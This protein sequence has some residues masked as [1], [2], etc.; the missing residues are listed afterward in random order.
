MAFDFL[1]T[2]ESIEQFE[3]FEEFVNIEARTIEKKIDTLVAQKLRY[4]ELLDK[5]K[6]ADQIQ[7]QGYSLAERSDINYIKN[8]RNQELPTRR[9]IDGFSSIAVDD[10]KKFTLEQIKSKRERN[11][12][13]IKK[14]RDLVE[15]TQ[16]EVNFLTTQL[17]KYEDNLNSI[18]ARFDL[19]DYPETQ[20]VAPIDEKDVDPNIPVTP[21]DSGREVVNGTT[22]Y[23]VLSVKANN[24]TITFDTA[25]PSVQPNQQITLINGQNNGVKTV[26][27]V[28]NERTIQVFEDL[29]DESPSPSKVSLF[30]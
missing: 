5:F 8:P 22:L 3:E 23:L 1:G 15:Q 7:R 16:N 11:E 20:K 12:Y 4:S 29:M 13:K 9:I 14:I 6:Q 17:D 10:L 28:I 25:A 2:I 30:V 19:A 18:R 26:F 21:R 27:K 24:R